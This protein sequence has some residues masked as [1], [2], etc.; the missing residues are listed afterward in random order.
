M[1]LGPRR[2]RR[3][4]LKQAAGVLRPCGVYPSIHH[5]RGALHRRGGE[6]SIPSIPP[7]G[8]VV[9]VVETCSK[10]H[11][12]HWIHDTCQGAGG[13]QTERAHSSIASTLGHAH[14]CPRPD[15]YLLYRP[16][17][18]ITSVL[19]PGCPRANRLPQVVRQFPLRQNPP[20]HGIG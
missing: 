13:K 7:Q 9:L 19:L 11:S 6:G 5:L 16:M 3:R 10:Q 14:T 2:D 20:R 4:S 18:C 15:R 8:S 17:E 12:I 1:C